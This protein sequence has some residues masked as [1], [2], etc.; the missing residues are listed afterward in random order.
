M[1]VKL[2]NISNGKILYKS[3]KNELLKQE[4]LL[5]ENYMQGNGTLFLWVVL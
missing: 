5:Y 4:K 2:L 3:L 1:V